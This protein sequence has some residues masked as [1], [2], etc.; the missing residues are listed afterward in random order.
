MTVNGAYTASYTNAPATK[1]QLNRTSTLAVSAT[2]TRASFTITF[3]K[4]AH[5]NSVWKNASG[6]A[7][8][9]VTAYYGD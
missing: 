8:T 4:D 3:G 6:T 5:P 7:T 1:T 2:T 9:S